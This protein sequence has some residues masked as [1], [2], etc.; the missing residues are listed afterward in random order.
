[1]PKGKGVSYFPLSERFFC[2]DMAF[3][4]IF[5]WYDSEFSLNMHLGS[6]IYI[7]ANSFIKKL[8][9]IHV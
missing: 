6:R 2:D 7:S 9:E 5:N 3:L 8:G 4:D 1:V